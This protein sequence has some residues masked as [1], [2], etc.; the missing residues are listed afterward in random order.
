MFYLKPTENQIEYKL[1]TLLKKF[2]LDVSFNVEAIEDDI[3]RLAVIDPLNKTTNY[4]KNLTGTIMF[5]ENMKKYYLKFKDK[6]TGKLKITFIPS[7]DK[8]R[9]TPI[10]LRKIPLFNLETAD[11]INLGNGIMIDVNYSKLMTAMA[12]RYA[13]E[14]LDYTLDE[15]EEKLDDIN[16]VITYDE[17]DFDKI[18]D[19]DLN[20]KVIK[21]F[22]IDKCPWMHPNKKE[23]YS[24][25]NDRIKNERGKY[26]TVIEYNAKK[27]IG[28][29]VG[30]M[31]EQFIRL[32]DKMGLAGMYEDGFKILVYD[33]ENLKPVL[34]YINEGTGIELFGRCFKYIPEVKI[35]RGNTK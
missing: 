27:F 1:G 15:I 10:E 24:F 23:I 13:Y 19:D 18:I 25:F 6:N 21:T 30:N 11:Y 14:D 2:H 7:E 31:L 28:L 22:K 12:F 35:I 3:S 17:K 9:S 32:R 16:I 34:D 4:R 29:I 5:L 26:D 33:E 20:Y 8:I